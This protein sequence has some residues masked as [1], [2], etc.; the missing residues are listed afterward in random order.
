MLTDLTVFVSNPTAALA[1][2]QLLGGSLDGDGSNTL[3]FGDTAIQVWRG[4]RPSH[5]HLSINVDDPTSTAATL[6]H[7]GHPVE[8][9]DE[10]RRMFTVS[11]PDGNTVM[12]RDSDCWHR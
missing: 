10:Q 12:V 3:W 7:R 4:D 1:F 11:D 9:T 5:V 2:Y 8:W 6:V